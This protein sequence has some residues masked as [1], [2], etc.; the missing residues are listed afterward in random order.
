MAVRMFAEDK[1]SFVRTEN[2]TKSS[3]KFDSKH[4]FDS[5]SKGSPSFDT[6]LEL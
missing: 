2:V 4:W 1:G 3:R 6:T 5:Q